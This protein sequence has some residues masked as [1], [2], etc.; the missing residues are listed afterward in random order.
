MIFSN[1]SLADVEILHPSLTNLFTWSSVYSD[2]YNFWV[3]AL[4]T[5]LFHVP[6]P[7]VNH[8]ITLVQVVYQFVW[9]NLYKVRAVAPSHDIYISI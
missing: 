9:V 6:S 5:I 2:L 8:S 7:V 4:S 3:V 1:I